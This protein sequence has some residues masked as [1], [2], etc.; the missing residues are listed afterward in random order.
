M[1]AFS[2]YVFVI[3]IAIQIGFNLDNVVVGAALGTSAVA[4][5]AVDA[6]ARR[7][8]AADLSNQFNGLMFP[9][10]VRFDAANDPDAL[11][12]C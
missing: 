1:T 2:L 8:S 7:L 4:V 11:R 5:Y 12:P 3:D 9:V 6:S 10:V